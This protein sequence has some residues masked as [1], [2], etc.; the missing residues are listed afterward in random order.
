MHFVAS[1]TGLLA[2]RGLGLYDRVAN[3]L[4]DVLSLP[5]VFVTSE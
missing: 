3:R 5:H 1:G 4:Y 2:I